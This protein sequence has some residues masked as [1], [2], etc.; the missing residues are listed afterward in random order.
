MTVA[1]TI[2]DSAK[3]GSITVEMPSQP[4]TGNYRNLTANTNCNKTASTKEGTD[5]ANTD[6]SV[7]Q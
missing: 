2:A 4:A 1:I 5:T 3:E 7:A 6:I